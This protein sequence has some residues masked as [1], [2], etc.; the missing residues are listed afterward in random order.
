MHNQKPHPFPQNWTNP[1]EYDNSEDYSEED[2]QAYKE[3]A[4]QFK[5]VLKRAHYIGEVDEAKWMGGKWGK[6]V[7][8]S[9][10][11]STVIFE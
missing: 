7:L 11:E 10:L 9:N 3:I 4:E 5:T 8:D 2:L 6:H 1:S